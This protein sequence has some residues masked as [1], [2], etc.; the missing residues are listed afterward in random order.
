MSEGLKNGRK[1][2]LKL[3]TLSRAW[4]APMTNN[5]IYSPWDFYCHM[6]IHPHCSPHTPPIPAILYTNLSPQSVCQFP[7]QIWLIVASPLPPHVSLPTTAL[8]LLF[9]IFVLTAAAMRML[10]NLLPQHPKP[11]GGPENTTKD[12][13]YWGFNKKIHTRAI[14][15][16]M[17]SLAKPSLISWPWFDTTNVIF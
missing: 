14:S 5:I 16:C 12:G 6:G 17:N 1:S 7:T 2:L 11:G 3:E 4:E 13:Q 8:C 9:P 15:V 10:L